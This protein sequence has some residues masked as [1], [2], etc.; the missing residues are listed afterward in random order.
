MPQLVL[1]HIEWGFS[2][3][4]RGMEQMCFV[5]NDFIFQCDKIDEPHKPNFGCKLQAGISSRIVNN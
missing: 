3:N 2:S 1:K 5:P 4:V